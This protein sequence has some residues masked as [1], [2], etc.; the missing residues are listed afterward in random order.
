MSIQRTKIGW[1]S[2]AALVLA[3]MIGTGAFTTLG[4][5]LKYLQSGWA[6][7]GLWLLGGIM[8]LFGAFSYAELGVRMPKS[9]GEAHFLSEIY[10][11]FLGFLSGWVSLSVGFA[12]AVALSAM[13]VGQYTSFLTGWPP[14]WIAVSSI[15]L[16]SVAHS[17]SLNYSSK[18]QNILTVL[19]L[20]LVAGLAIAGLCLPAAPDLLTDWSFNSINQS[21][22]PGAAIAL[23][24]I[25]YAYSGWNAAAYIVE[26]I[27]EADKNLP[28]ALIG[29]TIVV[30]I[31]F[32]LLQYAFLRQAGAA[33]LVGQIEVG[34]IAAEAMFGQQ[35]GSIISALIG[36]LL[37]AGISAMIWVGPRVVQA[38]GERHQIWRTFGKE[39]LNGLPLRA[40]WLQSGISLFLVFTAS[41]ERVL[42]YSGFVLQVFTFL[43]VLGLLKLR[44]QGKTAAKWQ[45]PLFPLAQL[46]FLGFSL[47]SMSYLLVSQPL[48]SIL[49]LLNVAAGALAYKLDTRE[50]GRSADA[51]K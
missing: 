51:L 1:K 45:S 4:I 17:M 2:A 39:S 11:P 28:R 5:Q 47:W 22:S 43:T 50:Y 29:G 18:L 14:I 25:F 48:E 33:A 30:S 21:W 38:M 32:I 34:Q 12:A 41:F 35:A 6:I 3:N 24:S 20:L 46:L 9:G 49:G 19:K 13:A 44:W 42:M 36:V 37:L 16:L 40:I 23:I 15:V 7:L 10:H 31:L 27:A 8:A 26:E